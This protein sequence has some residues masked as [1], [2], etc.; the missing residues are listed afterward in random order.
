ML[1]EGFIS[2]VFQLQDQDRSYMENCSV[3]L[4]EPVG[5]IRMLKV[6]RDQLGVSLK[7]LKTIGKEAVMCL[8]AFT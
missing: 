4:T 3:E 5:L 8:P 7:G 1:V 6:T 2:T